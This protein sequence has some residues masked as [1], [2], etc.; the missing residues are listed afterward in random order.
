MFKKATALILFFAMLLVMAFLWLVPIPSRVQVTFHG[1]ELAEDHSAQNT[2]DIVIDGWKLNYLFKTDKLKFRRFQVL[3]RTLSA[4]SDYALVYIGNIAA[5]ERILG[6]AWSETDRSSCGVDLFLHKEGKSCYIELDGSC[7]VGSVDEA[8]DPLTILEEFG[9]YDPAAETFSEM[10]EV[11]DWSLHG[12]WITA[13][14]EVQKA[15]DFRI[16]GQVD[17]EASGEDSMTLDISFPD[18]FPYSYTEKT[19][20]VSQSRKYLG[21][22]YCVSSAFSFRR[23]S[24]DPVSSHFVLCPE[25]EYVLFYWEAQPDRFLV[26]STDP[27]TN[28]QEILTYFDAFTEKF[29]DNAK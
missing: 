12:A 10:H 7:Y 13:A 2:G 5:Y 18:T 8:F 24:G 14:G 19:E 25:K 1:V 17:M 21:L 9:V 29:I 15:V 26:A 16:S 28:P 20:F 6:L 4:D 27:D 3:D 11:I 22:S 23:Y